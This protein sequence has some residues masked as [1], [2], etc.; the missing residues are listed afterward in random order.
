MP[1]FMVQ[2]TDETVMFGALEHAQPPAAAALDTSTTHTGG[3]DVQPVAGMQATANVQ[4]PTAHRASRPMS[5]HS[6]GPSAVA[7]GGY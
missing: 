1:R 4:L 2:D 6:A 7:A 3:S 5:V